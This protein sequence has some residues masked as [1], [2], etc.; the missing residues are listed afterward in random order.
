MTKNGSYGIVVLAAGN[1]SRLGEPK[2]LLHYN[3]KSLIRHVAECAMIAI[4][5]PVI[6]VTG[7]R[8][9]LVETELN[10][11]NIT[12]VQNNQ[13]NEGMGSSIRSGLQKLIDLNKTLQGV[14][15]AVSD[16]PFVSSALFLQL[17]DKHETSEKGIVAS[18]YGGTT[19]TPVL[20][21]KKYF[22]N[23]LE[24]RGAEG[25]KKLLYRFESDVQTVEFNLGGIDIDT[26]EDYQQLLAKR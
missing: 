19:G 11:L 1:S 13:W 7:Y 2:Q 14:I 6:V 21:D 16:Q 5:S 26:K 12:V 8:P 10:G 20:F 3:G 24:L 4:K 22:N 25:A 23:L 9:D 17:I 18:S 15:F